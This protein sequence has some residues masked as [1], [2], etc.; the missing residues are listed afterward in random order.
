[1]KD[2]FQNADTMTPEQEQMK[3]NLESIFHINMASKLANGEKDIP[4]ALKPYLD[5][6]YALKTDGSVQWRFTRKQPIKES[7]LTIVL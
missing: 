5:N 7:I 6:N 3:N 4:S 1:M 2:Y